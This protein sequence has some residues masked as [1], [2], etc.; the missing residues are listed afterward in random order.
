M[1]EAQSYYAGNIDK[2]RLVYLAPDFDRVTAERD[3]MQVSLTTADEWSE[4]LR[5]ALISAKAD[6]EAYAQNAIDLRKR[7]DALQA[8]LTAADER[9]DVLEGLLLQTNELL[10]AIQGDPGA[11]PSSSI[12]SMRGR[13]FE[14]LKRDKSTSVLHPQNL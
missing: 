1:S 9:A 12:D 5:S 2:D 11:V 10:Y 7:V 4:N 13:V 3:A 14:A 6:K 8:L